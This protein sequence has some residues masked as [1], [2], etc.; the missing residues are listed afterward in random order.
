MLSLM[1]K[2]KFPSLKGSNLLARYSISSPSVVRSFRS[3]NNRGTLEEPRT[4][5]RTLVT[6]T[7]S[8]AGL[9]II[10]SPLGGERNEKK[11]GRKGVKRWE[12]IIV[13]RNEGRRVKA[14]RPRSSAKIN[15]DRG[16]GRRVEKEKKAEPREDFWHVAV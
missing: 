2:K 8:R 9:L 16:R 11:R 14:S 7:R 15:K 6:S 13:R 4:C 3:M 12:I 10:A 1:K 5:S